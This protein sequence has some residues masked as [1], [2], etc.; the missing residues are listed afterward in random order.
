MNWK[1]IQMERIYKS[2]KS[3]VKMESDEMFQNLSQVPPH[4][5][6]LF[7]RKYQ[8]D[9]FFKNLNSLLNENSQDNFGDLKQIRKR[10]ELEDK[11]LAKVNREF[12][13]RVSDQ[14]SFCLQFEDDKLLAKTQDHVHNIGYIYICRK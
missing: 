6:K 7:Q 11:Y 4:H 3:E 12:S 14:G 8:E 1:C 9:P 2:G 5:K 10:F 13:E